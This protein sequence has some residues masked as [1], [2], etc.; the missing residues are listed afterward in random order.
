MG[1][2]T[3]QW[4][5]GLQDYRPD[6]KQWT[7]MWREDGGLMPSR[8]VPDSA[9]LAADSWLVD[10]GRVRALDR[11]RRRF[12]AACTEATGDSPARIES[13]WR[14]AMTMVPRTDRW[15]PRVEL[16]GP[17]PARLFL[18]IRPAPPRTAN[19]TVCLT[20]EFDPRAAPRRKGPDLSLLAHLR[21]RAAA[22]GAQELLLTTETGLVLE[23][24]G[25]GVLWWEDDVL[26]LPDPEL[27][28]FASV[29][30]AL[31]GERAA[32]LG[33]RLEHRRCTPHELDGREVW[34][35]NALHGIRPVTAWLGRP[36]RAGPALR[37][38]DW[39]T[40][41]DG[42]AEPSPIPNGVHR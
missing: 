20:E 4:G 7:L 28:L 14:D 27:P 23:G 35:V 6:Q 41:L 10:D 32:E 5:G 13:F 22:R 33:L 3:R 12:V 2:R 1:E 8:S 11:H 16:A 30:S 17:E 24:T 26:C 38:P 25:A 40:W 21:E 39:Q 34:L 15:F 36:L 31:I 37:A 19:V 18:R 29:T 9:V 42:S